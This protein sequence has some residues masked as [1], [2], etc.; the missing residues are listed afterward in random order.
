MKE[1]KYTLGQLLKLREEFLKSLHSP[2]SLYK[3]ATTWTDDFLR[4]I[5]K[6]E[7]KHES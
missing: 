6:W 3:N 5:V 4:W 2:L 7:E 1:E